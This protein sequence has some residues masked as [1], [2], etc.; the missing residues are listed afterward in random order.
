MKMDQFT[1]EIQKRNDETTRAVTDIAK[2]AVSDMNKQPEAVASKSGLMFN[3]KDVASAADA[4]H[5][6]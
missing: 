2:G 5:N 4:I 1:S 6:M 3:D